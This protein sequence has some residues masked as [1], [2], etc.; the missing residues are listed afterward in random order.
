ML[1]LCGILLMMGRRLIMRAYEMIGGMI[2]WP[3]L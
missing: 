2:N 1:P 3:F